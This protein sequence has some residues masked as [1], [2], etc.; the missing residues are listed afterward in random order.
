MASMMISVP[1]IIEFQLGDQVK[2]S[3][4]LFAT[5]L[6]LRAAADAEPFL[7]SIGMQRARKL[8]LIATRASP[9]VKSE[10]SIMQMALKRA[11]LFH[12][13]AVFKWRSS[14]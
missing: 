7:T 12:V 1:I 8:A 2:L 3:R 6:K 9:R 4:R 5:T 10:S 11:E 14:R 13:S